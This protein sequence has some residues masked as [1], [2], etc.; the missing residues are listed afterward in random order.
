[1]EKPE[2]QKSIGFYER[3][4]GRASVCFFI[5]LGFITF[6]ACKTRSFSTETAIPG[7]SYCAQLLTEKKFPFTT[8]QQ[9]IQFAIQN[10]LEFYK[11]EVQRAEGKNLHQVETPTLCFANEWII[12]LTSRAPEIIAG[13]IAELHSRMNKVVSL[14]KSSEPSQLAEAQNILGKQLSSTLSENSSLNQIEMMWQDR[15]QN[16]NDFLNATGFKREGLGI[17][18]IQSGWINDLKNRANERK[19]KKEFKLRETI[20]DIEKTLSILT[21]VQSL[22]W[23]WDELQVRMAYTSPRSDARYFPRG[24]TLFISEEVSLPY[25]AFLRPLAAGITFIGVSK[26]FFGVDPMSGPIDGRPMTSWDF[27][28][29]DMGHQL[30]ARRGLVQTFLSENI[31]PLA[32]ADTEQKMNANLIYLQKLESADLSSEGVTAEQ[33]QVFLFY[34]FHELRISYENSQQF[35]LFKNESLVKLILKLADACIQK[36]A[37]Y[38]NIC[39]KL[40]WSSGGVDVKSVK[41]KNDTFE[42]KTGFYVPLD[43]GFIYRNIDEL[44]KK[45]LVNQKTKEATGYRLDYVP[46]MLREVGLKDYDL[47]LKMR[48][49]L[50]N[51][52]QP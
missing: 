11:I 40:G 10:P 28:E 7:A 50:K 24:I 27:Y 47:I 2:M 19:K 33:W 6:S 46:S 3:I 34:V 23:D 45:D 37:P 35:S 21:Y 29:H 13:R 31:E 26:T 5:S 25:E 1:M 18:S 20:M 22:K 9:M 41:S 42:I 38:E 30:N 17:T 15:Q 32:P 14:I 52:S 51:L 48:N 44:I 49:K 36:P 16:E 43:P 12:D 4:F 39:S 8:Q